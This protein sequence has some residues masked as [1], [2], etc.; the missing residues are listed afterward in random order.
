MFYGWGGLI[1]EMVTRGRIVCGTGTQKEYYIPQ[2]VYWMD[3]DE[4][5]RVFLRRYFDHYG[6]ATVGDCRYFFGNA[7]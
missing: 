6:P 7:I 3:R 2:S 4:A 5:R 1:R